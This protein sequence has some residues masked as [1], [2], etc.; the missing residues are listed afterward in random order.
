MKIVNQNLA[1]ECGVC[2]CLMMINHHQNVNLSK[3]LILSDLKMKTEGLSI[4]ELESTLNKYGLQA[5]SYQVDSDELIENLVNDY[6]I[7]LIKNDELKHYV[8]IKLLNTKTIQVYCPEKGK[9]LLNVEQFKEVFLNVIVKIE[10][11]NELKNLTLF[12][13]DFRR[14]VSLIAQFII[15]TLELIGLFSGIVLGK[16]LNYLFDLVIPYKS[17]ANLINLSLIFLFF[18]IFTYFSNMLLSFY[19]SHITKK[20]FA[21][22]FG[23]LIERLKKKK[24]MFFNKTNNGEM[25]QLKVFI[26]Q[27]ISYQ[28]IDQPKL[29]TSIISFV[30]I[31]SILLSIHP[32]LIVIS[33]FSVLI[34]IGINL[35]S[36]LFYKKYS[37][38]ILSKEQSSFL[39]YQ[40]LLTIIKNEKN[41]NKVNQIGREAIEQHINL[42]NESFKYQSIN[43]RI[44]F[45]SEVL[46]GISFI[47]LI[48]VATYLYILHSTISIGLLTFL[49][50]IHSNFSESSS[51]IVAFFMKRVTF[52]NASNALQKCLLIDNLEKKEGIILEQIEDIKFKQYHFK[53]NTLL[54]GN[55]GVGKTSLLK[56]LAFNNEESSYFINGVPVKSLDSVF[57][58]DQIIYLPSNSM[59]SD[60]DL[61]KIFSRLDEENRVKFQELVR[62]T[63]IDF[64]N[65]NHGD[66]L[67]KLSS[68]Q[69]QIANF[70]NLMTVNNKMLL[71]DEPLSH[72]DQDTK[73]F[74]LKHFL[75]FLEKDNFII[76]VSHDKTLGRYFKEEVHLNA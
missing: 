30:I 54:T 75:V 51:G 34:N 17:L 6:Y 12:K 70:L 49:I 1:N 73:H 24:Q 44:T 15:F 72:V 11:T 46:N 28:L 27:I 35:I 60:F 33:L 64:L 20:V 74:L 55:S 14:N 43:T 59:S 9:Y 13:N 40:T 8:V 37:E 5:T 45:F 71:L 39:T 18:K 76:Y 31:F 66:T 52:K 67:R 50:F 25:N 53:V 62:R 36:Y 26:N 7:A 2:V 38:S 57:F 69:K 32:I 58:Q 10:K 65:I 22:S 3:N 48:G 61:T 16:F 19:V 56:E 4:Y 21:S 63:R 68:G 47:I 23:L 29:L 41:T 42:I